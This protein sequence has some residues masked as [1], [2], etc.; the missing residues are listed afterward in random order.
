[1]RS[2]TLVIAG[3]IA[4]TALSSASAATR[5]RHHAAPVQSGYGAEALQSAPVAARLGVPAVVHDQPY[6]CFTDE[7]YGRYASCDQPGFCTPARGRHACP[8]AFE[9]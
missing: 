8:S 5:H 7:G 1:M 2:I 6:A 9:Q 4:A 3:L